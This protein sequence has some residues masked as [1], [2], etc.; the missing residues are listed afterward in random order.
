MGRMRVGSG[1]LRGLCLV[2]VLSAAACGGGSSSPTSPTP[3]TPTRVINVSGNL[4]F[5]DVP[6]G[7]SRDLSFTISNSG[8]AALT[9]TS[10]SV[11]GGLVSQTAAS[12]TSGQIQAGGS[13][14]VTVRFAPTTAGSYSGTV[15]VNG[16]QT[17]GTNTIAISGN[18][19]SVNT[20]AGAW[21]GSY[22]V[23]RCDGTGSVQDIFCS[24]NRGLFPVGSTLPIAML[25]T[26]NGSSVSGTIAF[27]T[28]TGSV[29]GTVSGNSL[30]LQGTATSSG[31]VTTTITAW[32]TTISGNSMSGQIGYN[33]SLAG[34][35][36]VAAVTA[37]LASVT[38]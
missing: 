2:G 32:S 31:G 14:V 22:V 24:A 36:G 29:T 21:G 8:S 11:S 25:L 9:V 7:S 18:A 16:D 1:V 28:I 13:Q 23:E 10:L 17:S 38:K 19:V 33:L 37:R 26:Q 35:P 27:G 4:A 6:V 3:S 5:G 12:W 34:T 15:T 20:A 30:V